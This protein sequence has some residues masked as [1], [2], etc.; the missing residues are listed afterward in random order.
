MDY[1]CPKLLA[2]KTPTFTKEVGALTIP[3]A[4]PDDLTCYFTGMEKSLTRYIFWKQRC[5]RCYSEK[6]VKKLKTIGRALVCS[7]QAG[8]NTMN[9]SVAP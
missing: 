3:L 7:A 9:P 2:K 6:T 8:G 4:G 1:V 5:Q